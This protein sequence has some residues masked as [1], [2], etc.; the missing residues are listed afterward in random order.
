[1]M[2]PA[3]RII[4]APILYRHRH[5]SGMR[6]FGE[7]DKGMRTVWIDPRATRPA[8]TLLHELIH[9]R[10]PDWSE[11]RVRTEERRK[12]KEMTWKAKARLYLLLGKAALEGE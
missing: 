6:T 9:V 10:H 3:V 8:R 2:R 11:D 12:W 4:L 1:M 5:R 7:A